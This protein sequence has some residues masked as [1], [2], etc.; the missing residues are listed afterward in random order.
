[1]II[2]ATLWNLLEKCKSEFNLFLQILDTCRKINL[3]FQLI[4]L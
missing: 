1:M 2:E 3:I 4:E